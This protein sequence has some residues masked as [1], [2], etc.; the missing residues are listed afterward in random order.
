MKT[1]IIIDHY[2]PLDQTII[3]AQVVTSEGHKYFVNDVYDGSPDAF[4]PKH[5]EKLIKVLKKHVKKV[6][7]PN[8]VVEPTLT[9]V[10]KYEWIIDL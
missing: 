3:R 7:N 1:H 8:K 4:T 6:S 5:A 9:G 10:T 2:L